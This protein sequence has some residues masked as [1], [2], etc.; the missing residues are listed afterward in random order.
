MKV[1]IGYVHDDAGRVTSFEDSMAALVAFDREHEG[2]LSHDESRMTVRYGT[3]GLPAARNTIAAR[4]VGSDVDWLFWV[5]TDMGFA[6]DALYQLLAAADPTSRPI[7]GALCFAQRQFA[8]DGMF[9]YRTVPL[10]TIYDWRPGDDGVPRFASVPMYPVN[11]LV[12]SAATGCAFLLVHR[13]VFERVAEAHGPTWYDRMPGADGKLL[14]EDISF[15]ARAATVDVPVHVH[16]GVRTTHYKSRWLSEVDHWRAYNPPPATDEVAV[17]VP[18]LR[19]PQNAEPFMRSLRASTGLARV[20]A[21]CEPDDD[22]TAAAWTRAGAEVLRGD[23]EHVLGEPAG[24]VAHTFAEKVNLA[25][26]Q[27]REPWLFITGDDVKFHAGWLDHA[28]HVAAS[29]TD[30]EKGYA[31][32][33]V[34][35]NDLGNPRVM[36]GEHATHLLIRRSYVDEVGASW[37]GPGVVCHEGYGHWWVDEEI[38]TA[39]KARGVWQMALGGIVEHNHPLWGKAEDDEVYKLGQSHIEADRALFQARREEYL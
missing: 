28:L 13:S 29:F 23:D 33:V 20:Y 15:C 5:D 24:P 19:R 8:H 27:T 34:G 35:T 17:V 22:E 16:T 12:Q 2:F 37:D 18:V 21:V 14:G 25:Y 11:A 1:A 9:G 38:V 31:T 6:P 36:A 7:V 10:P 39:A 30:A 4:L 26:R 3:D 32:H